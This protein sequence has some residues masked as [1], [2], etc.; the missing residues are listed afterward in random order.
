MWQRPFT[1]R[2]PDSL[3]CPDC[4][5]IIE[6][7]LPSLFPAEYNCNNYVW[8]HQ[9]LWTSVQLRSPDANKSYLKQWLKLAVNVTWDWWFRQRLSRDLDLLRVFE[10]WQQVRS[11]CVALSRLERYEIININNNNKHIYFTRHP[12][13]ISSDICKCSGLIVTSN[14]HLSQI[15]PRLQSLSCGMYY[16]MESP[17]RFQFGSKGWFEKLWY[18]YYDKNI[19]DKQLPQISNEYLE[20]CRY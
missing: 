10:T 1:T 6:L 8:L 12:N 5:D 11:G 20:H 14:M 4:A 18:S 15:F 13:T 2:R 7:P 16:C 19:A 9:Q 3:I 17:W